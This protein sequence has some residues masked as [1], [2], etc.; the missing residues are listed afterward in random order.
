ML[1][2]N[3]RRSGLLRWRLLAPLLP[4]LLGI[5]TIATIAE[6]SHPPIAIANPANLRSWEFDPYTQQLQ[7]TVP[8]GSTPRYLVLQ[9]PPRIAID[10]PNSE[11][12]RQ[13]VRET[14][15]GLVREIRIGQFEPGI[16]RVVVELAPGM[17]IAPSQ[18]ELQP[19]GQSN[20]W[21]LNLQTDLSQALPD[22]ETTADRGDT[23]PQL[24][25]AASGASFDPPPPPPT[26]ENLD[27]NGGDPPPPPMLSVEVPSPDSNGIDGAESGVEFDLP[28]AEETQ[29]SP[30]PTVS[31]PGP[32]AR[33]SEPIAIAENEAQRQPESQSEAIAIEVPQLL[34]ESETE[35]ESEPEAARSPVAESEERA[36]REAT[37]EVSRPSTSPQR[38]GPPTEAIVFGQPLP[39]SRAIAAISTRA[40]PSEIGGSL[41]WGDRLSAPKS[42]ERPTESAPAANASAPSER[43]IAAGTFLILSYPGS[44]PFT[45]DAEYPRQEVL[46][47][48][49]DLYDRAGNLSIPLGTPVI[50][51]FMSDRGTPR[52]VVEAIVL[53]GRTVPLAAQSDALRSAN[54]HTIQPGQVLPVRLTE[55]W[56]PQGR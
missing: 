44:A 52:F 43:A 11:L 5:S 55:H 4:G 22:L 1:M 20:R 7:V 9:D 29:T 16:A 23:L 41:Q 6:L 26:F 47:V 37:P 50:G 34:S 15:P 30:T 24:P 21:V 28:I 10:I 32:E 39:G 12:G 38:N 42:E 8:A 19:L 40:E 54:P 3:E 18:V 46:V 27:E 25:P 45:L 33:D 13:P 35:A 53:D 31:V 14:Y 49:A 56:Q 51:K 17:A 48:Q 36:V 2:K